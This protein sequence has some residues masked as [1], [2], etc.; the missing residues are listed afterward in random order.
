[1]GKQQVSRLRNNTKALGTQIRT[2]LTAQRGLENKL[3]KSQNQLQNVLRTSNAQLAQIMGQQSTIGDL[4]VQRNKLKL[5]RNM[6][7]GG[8]LALT[9]QRNKL[10]LQRNMAEGGRLALT[11][12]RQNAQRGIN[13]LR[14]TTRN[15]EQR[16][17]ASNRVT[18]NTF[19][20][21]AAFNKQL[22]SV[23]ARQSWKS[24][25]PKATMI[26]ASRM[27]VGKALRQKLLKNIDVTNL[28]GKHVVDGLGKGW[29]K[30]PG[31]ERRDLKKEVR[32]PMTGLNRLRAIEKM[33]LDRKTKR[34]S[35]ILPKRRMNQ[36]IARQGTANRFKFGNNTQGQPIPTGEQ[37]RYRDF[38]ASGGRTGLYN[39]TKDTGTTRSRTS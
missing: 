30:L 11:K 23:A 37:G 25:K 38:A 33:I 21:S 4:K 20:A 24:L 7:E 39:T 36:V 15:L 12:Q 10:K 6:T 26:G 19:N 5:Q 17:L 8:R 35:N 9:K 31:G 28:N 29:N 1:V 32:D 13:A 14:A 3:S 16:R 18:N 27:G 22:K 2:G 34:N